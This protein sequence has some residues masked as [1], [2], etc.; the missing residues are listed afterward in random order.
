MAGVYR[1]RHPERTVLY[2]VLFHYFE[3]FLAKYE[4]R[5][6]REYRLCSPRARS[7]EDGFFRPI[8]KE[9]VEK[10]LD[11]GNPKCGFALMIRCRLMRTAKRCP[12]QMS[13]LRRGAARYVLLPDKGILPIVPCQAD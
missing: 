9:A 8:V 6:K 13:R 1:P 2:R 4:D 3:R 5:F 10:Y 7:D 11:C 12:H